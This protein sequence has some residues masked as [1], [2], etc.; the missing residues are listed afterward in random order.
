[1]ITALVRLRGGQGKWAAGRQVCTGHLYLSALGGEAG[2]KEARA[3]LG[4]DG[5]AGYVRP[6]DAGVEAHSSALDGP[7]SIV[8]GRL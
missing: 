2:E 6:G 8:V 3:Y 1:M 4:R 5:N 7:L